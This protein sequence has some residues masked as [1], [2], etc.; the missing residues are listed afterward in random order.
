M[1]ITIT[2]ETPLPMMRK[3]AAMILDLADHI[4]HEL[5]MPVGQVVAQAAHLVDERQMPLPLAIPTPTPLQTA[6]AVAPTPVPIAP[7]PS[8]GAVLTPLAPAH[9]PI[10][11]AENLD[12]RGVPHDPRIHS[13]TRGIT[14]DGSWRKLRGVGDDMVASVEAEIGRY[15]RVG[16][17]YVRQAPGTP[18]P[19]PTPP[20]APSSAAAELPPIVPE[21]PP[22]S[23]PVPTLVPPPPTVVPPPP[24]VAPIV[25]ALAAAGPTP[26]ASILD[27]PEPRDFNEFMTSIVML[28]PHTINKAMLDACL[29]KAGLQQLTQLSADANSVKAVWTALKMAALGVN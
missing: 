28:M 23:N 18:T 20:A 13:S 5:K 8:M 25:P 14:A 17:S 29:A 7:S 1:Q 26:A 9:P 2:H 6:E 21:E 16:E 27:M 19:V 15:V 10:I 4:E 3:A 12:S 24:P 22:V 11:S